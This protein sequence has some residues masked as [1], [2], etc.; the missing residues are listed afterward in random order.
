MSKPADLVRSQGSQMKKGH[1][2]KEWRK[3]DKTLTEP[4]WDWVS[5]CE[6]VIPA[7]MLVCTSVC[8]CMDFPAVH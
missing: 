2:D 4:H 3:S 7:R 6:P 1:R 8:T 5:K